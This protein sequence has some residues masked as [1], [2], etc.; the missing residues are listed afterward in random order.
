ML[1]NAFEY[2]ESVNSSDTTEKADPDD[3]GKPYLNLATFR[4][5]V[6]AE[7]L[8]ESFFDED[9]RLSWKLEILIAEEKPKAPGAAGWFDDLLGA[10]VTDEN[11][12]SL[13]ASSVRQEKINDSAAGTTQSN[14][15]CSRT[16]VEDTNRRAAALAGEAHFGNVSSRPDT[17]WIPSFS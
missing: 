11:K 14:R 17:P 2:A 3:D 12:V 1:H 10:I 7:E 15:G 8:L 4:M 16:I 5:V 9:F 13:L 6:L